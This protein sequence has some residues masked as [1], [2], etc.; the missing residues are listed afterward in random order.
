MARASEFGRA[1]RIR[2]HSP[3]HLI[4]E[5]PLQNTIRSTRGQS[6]PTAR[7]APKLALAALASL[8]AIGAAVANG[9]PGGGGP[10]GGGPPFVA[11][12][13]HSNYD[14]NQDGRPDYRT[15][16][17]YAVEHADGSVTGEATLRVVVD[18]LDFD[19]IPDIEPFLEI[20]QIQIGGA[21]RFS[22]TEALVSGV[23]TESNDPLPCSAADD[24]FSLHPGTQLAFVVK[25]NGHGHVI[26]QITPTLIWDCVP[27][28]GSDFGVDDSVSFAQW[29]VDQ[30][31]GPFVG[32]FLIDIELGDMY[33]R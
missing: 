28:L 12:G 14:F 30:G 31:F 27:F 20:V 21:V 23:V 19:G 2:R 15:L 22:D 8:V 3:I 7:R 1:R 10:G 26:D 33:V 18:D 17:F 9:G 6:T 29:A 32:Q 11:A 13:A 24:L 25:D 4:M 16:W 5:E